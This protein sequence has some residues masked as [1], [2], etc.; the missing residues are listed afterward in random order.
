MNKTQLLV[1]YF[2]KEC[3]E[4]LYS[5]SKLAS[6]FSYKKILAEGFLRMLQLSFEGGVF[7]FYYIPFFLLFSHKKIV[8]E[9]FS[10]KKHYI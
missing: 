8:F 3:L 6:V 2:S 1:V 10:T 5:V 9:N 7:L 4:K